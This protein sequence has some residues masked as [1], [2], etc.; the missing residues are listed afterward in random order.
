ML[1]PL[2]GF[3]RNKNILWPKEP[4]S[5][6]RRQKLQTASGHLALDMVQN[7]H[8]N[9]KDV[10]WGGEFIEKGWTWRRWDTHGI[11]HGYGSGTSR[12]MKKKITQIS[13]VKQICCCIVVNSILLVE[14]LGEANSLVLM[15]NSCIH[16]TNMYWIPGM[17]QA[18]KRKWGFYLSNQTQS[19]SPDNTH[20]RRA[21]RYYLVISVQL[22]PAM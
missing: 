10:Q 12:F 14:T 20:S 6:F 1:N 16:S 15:E 7:E 2:W 22:P 8:V 13:W 21:D 9:A 5:K 17:C 4:L 19:L 11:I 18:L 3:G